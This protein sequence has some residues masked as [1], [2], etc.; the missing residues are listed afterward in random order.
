MNCF[1]YPANKH[2]STVVKIGRMMA[3]GENLKIAQLKKKIFFL[4]LFFA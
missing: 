2:K 4:K 1:N 3:Q